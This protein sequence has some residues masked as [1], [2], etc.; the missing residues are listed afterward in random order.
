MP[1]PFPFT[2]WLS[3]IRDL[4]LPP[5]IPITL[6]LDDDTPRIHNI[7][8][9]FD[10]FRDKLP[11]KISDDFRAFFDELSAYY[12]NNRYPDLKSKLSSSIGEAEANATFSKAK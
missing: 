11:T 3:F 2:G 10:N 12:V 4:H 6:Y 1:I 8:A 5:M 9:I 7:K